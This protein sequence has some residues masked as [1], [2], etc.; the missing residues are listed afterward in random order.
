MAGEEKRVRAWVLVKSSEPEETAKELDG[1]LKAE[2]T[3]PYDKRRKDLV[4]VRA[5]VVEGEYNVIVPVD[6]ANPGSLKQALKM[7]ED[8][9]GTSSVTVCTVTTH[10]PDPPHSTAT[11][12]TQ[13]EYDADRVP[14]FH[15]PGLH[16]HSPGRNAWG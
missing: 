12:V 3:K 14:E 13:K 9:R 4:I 1:K 8:A 11:F 2:L 7:I 5:D 10:Y 15:P 6:A 16:P